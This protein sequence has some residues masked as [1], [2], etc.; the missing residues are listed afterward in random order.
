MEDAKLGR[1]AVPIVA[2]TIFGAVHAAKDSTPGNL[3]LYVPSTPQVE[4]DR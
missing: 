2:K 4:V 3:V 1:A